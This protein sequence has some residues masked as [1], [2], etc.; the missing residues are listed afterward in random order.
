MPSPQSGRPGSA[1]S[2]TDPQEAKEADK[3][4]PGEVDQIKAEDRKTQSGKYGSEKVKPYKAPETKE[5]KAKTKS[6]IG[7]KLVNEE[8]KP[9]AGEKYKVTLSDGE[10]VAEGT[11]DEKGCARVEGIEPGNCQITFPEYD[12][13]AWKKN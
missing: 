7:I 2:P 3:A 1:V 11:L 5:E 4:D 10:T 6:W 9:V 13:K 12:K 8:K